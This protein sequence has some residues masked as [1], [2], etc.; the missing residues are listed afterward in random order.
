MSTG[1]VSNSTFGTLPSD[2]SPAVTVMVGFQ[3]KT[4]PSA[5]E[6]GRGWCVTSAHRDRGRRARAGGAE[7]VG[8]AG[9]ERVGSCRHAAPVEARAVGPAELG[10]T[11]EE[12]DLVTVPSVSMRSPRG[13]GGGRGEGRAVGG[14]GERDARQRV[15]LDADHACNGRHTVGVEDEEHVSRAVRRRRWPGR[16]REARRASGEGERDER[17]SML[18]E[19]VTVPR[20]TSATLPIDAGLLVAISIGAP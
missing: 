18:S 9:G 4:A 20:R 12:L 6:D 5:G 17:C 3:E 13:D 14:L 11:V 15:A 19:C 10:R 1:A 2:R 16:R 8:G 7:A